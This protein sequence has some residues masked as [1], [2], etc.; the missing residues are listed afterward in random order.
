M[1]PERMRELAVRL[2]VLER[3]AVRLHRGRSP[4]PLPPILVRPAPD[5]LALALPP[6]WLDR[7][8]LTRADLETETERVKALGLRLEVCEAKDAGAAVAV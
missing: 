7:N 8:P 4:S 5:G 3:L 1:L 2:A 6:G